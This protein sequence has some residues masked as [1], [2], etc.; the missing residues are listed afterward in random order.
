MRGGGVTAR[1]RRGSGS[2]SSR[3]A[4][5]D[6]RRFHQVAATGAG[7]TRSRRP[8]S[9]DGVRARLYVDGA[10]VAEA[11]VEADALR[12]KSG[13][14]LYIGANPD[15]N[16]GAGAFFQGAIDEVRISALAR[17]ETA[18]FDPP[19]RHEGDPQTLLL[20]HL[21]RDDGP[22]ALDASPGRRHGIGIGAVSFVAR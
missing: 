21:D 4:P 13:L 14:P 20:L 15:K 19:A 22:F 8:A 1:A 9:D 6:A 7:I 11:E 17:Y 12:L 16:G 3:P 18:R 10:E 2:W 5:S